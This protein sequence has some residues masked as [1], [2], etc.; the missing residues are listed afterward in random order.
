MICIIL[1]IPNRA[2]ITVKIAIAVIF[3]SVVRAVIY[4]IKQNYFIFLFVSVLD[5]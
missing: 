4:K 1:S 5:L 3:I 2:R